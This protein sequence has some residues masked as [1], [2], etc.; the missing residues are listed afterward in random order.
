MSVS[1]QEELELGFEVSQDKGGSCSVCTAF[2]KK[3]HAV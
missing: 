3:E 1:F 2:L